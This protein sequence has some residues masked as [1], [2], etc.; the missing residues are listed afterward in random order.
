MLDQ[1]ALAADLQRC[2]GDAWDRLQGRL[3]S[4]LSRPWDDGEK[5]VTQLRSLAYSPDRSIRKR[6]WE[7]ECAAWREA[8]TSFAPIQPTK[9]SPNRH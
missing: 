8:E 4:A 3:S 9:E 6:A 2:G 7:E 1:E 5:T